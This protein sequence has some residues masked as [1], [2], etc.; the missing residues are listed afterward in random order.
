MGVGPGFDADS[1]FLVR[2]DICLGV[3]DTGAVIPIYFK[4]L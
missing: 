1:V 2:A 4:T 3:Y